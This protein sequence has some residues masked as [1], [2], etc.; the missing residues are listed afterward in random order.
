MHLEIIDQKR[1]N[2]LKC[3]SSLPFMSQFSMGGGTSLS[4]QLGLRTSVDFDFFSSEHFNVNSLLETIKSSFDNVEVINIDEKL[5]TLDLFIDNVKVSFFEYKYKL[6]ESPINFDEFNNLTLLSIYDI[7]AMKIIAIIQRGTKKDFFDLYFII[8][9]FSLSISDLFSILDKKYNNPD[10]KY[11][12]MMSMI[13][14]E[15]AENDILPTCFV[16]YSWNEIKKYFF[17]LQKDAKKALK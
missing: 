13:Y 8:K 12:F 7:A 14:F 10:L 4:L 3:L 9:N 11:A 5:S 1:I 6:L 2:L 15:D 17:T 16:P